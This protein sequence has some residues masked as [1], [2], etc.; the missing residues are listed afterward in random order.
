MPRRVM[1]LQ[2]TGTR[3][4]D[5]ASSTSITDD[6]VPAGS[7][8]FTVS[9]PDRFK[10]GDGVLVGRPVT[11]QWIALLGMDKLV[12]NGAAQTWITPGTILRAERVVAAIA[13]NKLTLDAPHPDSFVGQ[14]VRPPG[15]SVM[16]Y[17]FEG[18]IANV[19]VERLRAV[20]APRAENV[21]FNWMQMSAVVDAW[22]KDVVSHDFT[23]GYSIT[24]TAQRITIEDAVVSHTPGAYFTA[25]APSDF[26][27]D[28]S[29]LLVNRGASRGANKIF[30]FSTAGNVVG[31][32]VV[33]N[34]TASGIR[35]H[36]QPHQRWATGLLV[37]STSLDDGNIEYI[38]RG[39]L[40]SGHGWTMGWGVIW[41]SSASS[42]RAEQ[43]EGAANWAIGN[44]GTQAGNGTFDSHGTPVV[45][46]SLYLA[47]LCQRV[48]PAALAALGY[49]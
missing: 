13:G 12:R 4:Q 20:G 9:D 48:G 2:G 17:S 33:L 14:Y 38:N 24:D 34:F 36:L 19:G 31:P 5:T 46:R 47:Q 39:N 8:V 26:N 6:S 41:N 30:Y 16:K 32:N 49:K 10:V 37:D 45:P 18:R 44:K 25:A 21:N 35:S 40:G 22:V 28:G 1:F 42:I 27:I 43:P 15:G 29:Q 11:A 7:S 23:T 3:M